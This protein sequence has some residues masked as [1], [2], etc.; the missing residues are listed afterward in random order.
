MTTEGPL[1]DEEGWHPIGDVTTKGFQVKPSSSNSTSDRHDAVYVRG[2]MHLLI[3]DILIT[4]SPKE[5]L[6]GSAP[7]DSRHFKTG[8]R[9]KA[10]EG[11]LS[12]C[13]VNDTY[14]GFD[15]SWDSDLWTSSG[16]G[17]SSAGYG[18]PEVTNAVTM[19]GCS[20]GNFGAKL[21]NAPTSQIIGASWHNRGG[22]ISAI[23]SGSSGY[24]AMVTSIDHGLST[25]DRVTIE[26]SDSSPSIDGTWTV[27][28][29]DPS[30]FAVPVHGTGPGVTGDWSQGYTRYTTSGSHCLQ[31]GADAF[32][33][34]CQ[35]SNYD[36]NCQ[37]LHVVDHE[38]FDIDVGSDPGAWVAGGSPKV[39]GQIVGCYI[40]GHEN[41]LIGCTIQRHLEHTS[42]LRGR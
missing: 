41:A 28:V 40:N 7:K 9:V 37:N 6:P 3:E 30:T 11:H 13:R 25:G 34:G 18:K 31:N 2:C 17:K 29:K 26:R 35:N 15:L 38:Q 5:A 1:Y 33:D 23:S 39:T 22:T 10:W 16:G 19:I 14:T 27:T 20:Y 21:T 32:V 36:R 4:S 12:R 24:P 8:I 42:T